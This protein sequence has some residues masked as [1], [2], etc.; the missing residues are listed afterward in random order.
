MN[1]YNKN[2]Q[3]IILD[4]LKKELKRGNHGNI[5]QCQLGGIDVN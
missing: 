2:F 3:K 4:I 5:K 1:K